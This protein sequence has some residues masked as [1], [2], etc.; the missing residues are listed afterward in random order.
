M[1][2]RL[3]KQSRYAEKPAGL[4]ALSEPDKGSNSKAYASPTLGIRKK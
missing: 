1:G 2:T 4:W 3:G